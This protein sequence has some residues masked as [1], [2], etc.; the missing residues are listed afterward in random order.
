MRLPN[1]KKRLK[2]GMTGKAKITCGSRSALE[3]LTRRLA[4]FIRVEFW[5]YW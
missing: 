5:S 4:R 2:T 3:L 1:D